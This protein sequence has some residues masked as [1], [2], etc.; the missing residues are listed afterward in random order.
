MYNKVPFK[1]LCDNPGFR[2]SLVYPGLSYNVWYAVHYAAADF[3]SLFPIQH[4]VTLPCH[5]I[6]TTSQVCATVPIH[7]MVHPTA[8][9]LLFKTYV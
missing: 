3:A 2:I 5:L 9:P 6:L 1:I 7:Q 8:C 4:T